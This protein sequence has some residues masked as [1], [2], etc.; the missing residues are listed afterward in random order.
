MTPHERSGLAYAVTGFAVLSCGD[1]VV[2]SMAGEWPP[3]AVAA[4]RFAIGAIGLSVLLWRKEGVEAF[5]PQ[6]WKLQ[7]A[8]GICL[9][10]ASACFA[11]LDTGS[12]ICLACNFIYTNNS[13]TAP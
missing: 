9:A 10:F 5:R 6:N 11:S 2:K 1:A 13:S 3:Y 8:R 4:L 12:L 7:L